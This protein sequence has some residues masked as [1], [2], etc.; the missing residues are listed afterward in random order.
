M[1]ESFYGLRIILLFLILAANAFFASAEVILLT[2]RKSRL[3]QLA[4]EG[5]KGAKAALS[6]LA[7]P[8]RLLASTQVGV[9]LATLGLGWA[10]EDTIYSLLMRTLH[11]LVTP[12]TSVIVHGVSFVL[13]FLLMTYAHAVIGEV[14]P[15]NL[16][17]EKADRLA[18][19]IALALLIFYRI[20]APFVYV[21]ERS[22]SAV[23]RAIGLGEGHGGAG[24][25]A[26]ELKMIVSLSRGSG[27]LPPLQEEMIHRIIDLEDVYVRQI[28]VPRNEI[29][30]IPVEATLEEALRTMI[31]HQHSRIPVYRGKPEQIVGVL[32]YKDMLALWASRRAAITA[33]RRVPEF[34]IQKLMHKY[35]VA[36]E[37]KPV[38]SM[39][40]EFKEGKAHMAMVVD[41]FGTIVGLVTV[42]DVLEQIVGEIEDEYDVKELRP[43]TESL[44][45]ELEGATNIRDLELLHGIEIPGNAGFETLAGFL[46]MK[47]G[48]IPKQGEVVEEG[49]R[50]YTVLEM[51]RNRIAKVLVE[52]L[53]VEP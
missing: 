40:E 49:G 39:L 13:A 28:M 41:E 32:F 34:R 15:K 27:H 30:S 35:M 36:P 43:A 14:V 46:L 4:D 47:L 53:E 12:A 20:S 29:V 51:D 26:E 10:G 11:P 2:A 9:T 18:S 7:N 31:E 37:T 16:G 33:G 5:D 3:R 23:S 17:I 44:A 22:S 50:R 38:V 25:S 48:Y 52:K 1:D 42:E 21:I 8:Q 45:L 24:H 19:P 6:L